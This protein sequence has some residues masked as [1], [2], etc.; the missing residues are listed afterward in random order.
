ME[1][2]GFEIA[3]LVASVLIV[4]RLLWSCGRQGKRRRW[5]AWLTEPGTVKVG[6][7]LQHCF[8]FAPSLRKYAVEV[9][10]RRRA[11]CLAAR[12]TK[13]LESAGMD[14]SSNITCGCSMTRKFI[15][16][17]PVVH[18]AMGQSWGKGERESNEKGRRN[19]ESPCA[20]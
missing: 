9:N 15:P 12:F 6:E 8:V 5:K 17:G 3:V 1:A 13:R 11:W 19:G 14:F 10:T 7:V 4:A 20:L 2:L 16:Q 18:D